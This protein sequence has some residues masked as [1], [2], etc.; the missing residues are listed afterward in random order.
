MDSLFID[1]GK[2]DIEFFTTADG[3]INIEISGETTYESVKEIKEISKE[4]LQ[5]YIDKLQK[6][7]D[8]L[9]Y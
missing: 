8:N 1:L 3:T 7:H 6:M 2:T 9:K 5:S 4:T